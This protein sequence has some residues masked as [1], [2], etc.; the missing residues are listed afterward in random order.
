MGHEAA[1]AGRPGS[2]PDATACIHSP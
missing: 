1:A 2:A